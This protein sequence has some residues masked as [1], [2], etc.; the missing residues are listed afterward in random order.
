MREKRGLEQDGGDRDHRRGGI[1]RAATHLDEDG[2]LFLRC[3]LRAPGAGSSSER[4]QRREAA[5][6]EAGQ[7]SA[8]AKVAEDHLWEV[9]Q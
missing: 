4:Q 6:H 9:L 2:T 1:E 3:A 8:G 7:Q 5:E